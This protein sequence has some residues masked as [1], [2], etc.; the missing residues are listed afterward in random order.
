MALRRGRVAPGGSGAWPLGSEAVDDVHGRWAPRQTHVPRSM[1][2]GV[3]TKGKTGAITGRRL[4]VQER[5]SCILGSSLS[6]SAYSLRLLNVAVD[7]NGLLPEA[8]EGTDAR[9]AAPF[10][11][12]TTPDSVR[13]CTDELAATWHQRFRT[14]VCDVHLVVTD[15]DPLSVT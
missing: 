11:F 3:C 9:A 5:S 1:A 4:A 7:V 12:H 14:A 8:T 2:N 6:G 15:A 13:A 10:E